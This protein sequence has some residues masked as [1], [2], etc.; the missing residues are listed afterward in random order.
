MDHHAGGSPQQVETVRTCQN[1]AHAKI[2]CLRSQPA[3]ACDRCRR[4]RKDCVFRPARRRFGGGS[5]G[6]SAHHPAPPLPGSAATTT[7]ASVGD[8]LAAITNSGNGAAANEGSQQQQQ[9]QLASIEAKLDRL[10]SLHHGGNGSTGQAS[11]TSFYN[12]PRPPSSSSPASSYNPPTVPASCSSSSTTAVHPPLEAR[13][14]SV[15]GA[16]THSAGGDI[17]DDGI[18]SLKQ[19]QHCIQLYRTALT[20][21]FPFVVLDDADGDEDG[22]AA[23]VVQRLRRERPFLFLAVVTAASFEDVGVQRE[24]GRRLREVVGERVAG[25]G[26]GRGRR[27]AGVDVDFLM[28]LLVGLAW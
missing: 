5:G 11:A 22:D 12:A 19:A 27:N 6:G 2:R 20:P 15:A 26:G 14:N 13:S 10:L 17:I 18:I 9:Q 28:G 16:S 7:T 21:H 25:R 23:A 1:C 3:G 8:G 24:C 4:L